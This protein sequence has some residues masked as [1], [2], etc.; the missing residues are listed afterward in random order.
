[1]I[2]HIPNGSQR[3]LYSIGMNRS[4][5]IPF[6]TDFISPSKQKEDETVPYGGKSQGKPRHMQTFQLR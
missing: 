4:C 3:S 6:M 1:M 2:I 5:S